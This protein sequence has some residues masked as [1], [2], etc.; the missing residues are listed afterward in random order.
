MS[1]DVKLRRL[2]RTEWY[3]NKEAPKVVEVDYDT[4]GYKEPEHFHIYKMPKRQNYQK[5]RS[6]HDPE[7]LAR[8]CTP[9]SVVLERL[10][11][12]KIKIGRKREL[13]VKIRDE[14]KI[15]CE[16]KKIVRTSP[17]LRNI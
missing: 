16:L 11:L 17:R 2:E 14:D 7:F 6:L 3:T 10:D 12:S 5:R 1:E 15:N 4:G 9:L 13:V 8:F